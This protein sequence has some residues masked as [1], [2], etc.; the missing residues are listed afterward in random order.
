[1]H[2]AEPSFKRARKP[3]NHHLIPQE[4]QNPASHPNNPDHTHT[5][6]DICMQDL[7]QQ[8]KRRNDL[9][10]LPQS[11]SRNISPAAWTRKLARERTRRS[12][13][14]V[15]VFMLGMSGDCQYKECSWRFSTPQ[16]RPLF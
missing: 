9:H 13:Y 8:M 6:F 1:M 16:P 2:L 12:R 15:N 10:Q 14:G 7:L 3:H 5:P 4:E 11:P